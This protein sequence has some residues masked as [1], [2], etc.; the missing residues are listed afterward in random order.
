MQEKLVCILVYNFV[1]LQQF[2]EEANNEFRC[3]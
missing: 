3:K 1:S 2:F